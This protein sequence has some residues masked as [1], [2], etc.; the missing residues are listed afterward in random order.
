MKFRKS[1]SRNRPFNKKI[2]KFKPE[3]LSNKITSDKTFFLLNN[4][5][6]N[7]LTTT[8]DTLNIY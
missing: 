4:M 5:L 8:I 2:S 6:R 1:K 3:L 7:F